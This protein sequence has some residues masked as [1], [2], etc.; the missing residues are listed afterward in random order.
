MTDK[1]ERAWWSDLRERL[2]RE[3]TQEDVII[4]VQTIERL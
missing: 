1:F 2:M 3:F 4:R